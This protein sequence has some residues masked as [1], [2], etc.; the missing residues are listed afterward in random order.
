[1]RLK[2]NNSHVDMRLSKMEVAIKNIASFTTDGNLMVNHL[3]EHDAAMAIT[4]KA[5][6]A[7][8]PKCT[9]MM[10]KSVRQAVSRVVETLA[11]A[12]K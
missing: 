6:F 12:P 1:M 5:I 11:N 9:T 3:M 7:E 10:A 2:T 8:E 4:T